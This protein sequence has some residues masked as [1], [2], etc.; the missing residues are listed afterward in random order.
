MGDAQ[1]IIKFI[2][3]ASLIQV[4]DSLTLYRKQIRHLTSNEKDFYEQTKTFKNEIDLNN[5]WLNFMESAS[6]GD[7]FSMTSKQALM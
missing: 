2:V 1:H 5:T 6:N 4:S 3:F 7:R